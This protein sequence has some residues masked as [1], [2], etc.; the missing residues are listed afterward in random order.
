M[1]QRWQLARSGVGRA[2]LLVVGFVVLSGCPAARGPAF[3]EVQPNVGENKVLLYVFRTGP[4]LFNVDLEIGDKK[5]LRFKRRS[6]TWLALDPG[7]YEI[8]VPGDL[9]G[10]V[11][12]KCEQRLSLESRVVYLEFEVLGNGAGCALVSAS[13]ARALMSD[14]RFLEPLTR[15]HAPSIP[16]PAASGGR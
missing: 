3:A 7:V 4:F 2:A 5:I 14:H 15:D 11:G 16:L 13:V 12:F 1:S 8:R 6:F 10:R 9:G